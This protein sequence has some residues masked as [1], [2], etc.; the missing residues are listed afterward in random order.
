MQWTTG[1]DK[2]WAFPRESDRM[3]ALTGL[4]GF[5]GVTEVRLTEEG[6]SVLN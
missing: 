4:P 2:E 3:K 1:G 5:R 6:T